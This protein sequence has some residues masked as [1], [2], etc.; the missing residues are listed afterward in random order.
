MPLVLLAGVLVGALGWLVLGRGDGEDASSGADDRPLRRDEGRRD[1]AGAPPTTPPPPVEVRPAE[2]PLDPA[3]IT[4]PLPLPAGRGPLTGAE[5]IR[6]VEAAGKVRI[7]GATDADLDALR[8]A[9]FEEADRAGD[10]P[11]AAMMGWL[12]EAGFEAEASGPTLVVRRR[13]DE[14]WTDR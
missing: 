14:A 8:R 7:R 12:K 5:L 3:W 2:P 1:P 10:W 11:H 4:A 9:T 6:A 13:T